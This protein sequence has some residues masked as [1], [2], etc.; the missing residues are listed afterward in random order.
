MRPGR[1]EPFRLDLRHVTLPG[2]Y[3][4]DFEF[5]AQP[6]FRSAFFTWA[7]LRSSAF[8]GVDLT[9]A[10]FTDAD[11]RGCLLVSAKLDEAVLSGADLRGAHLTGASL[12]G[13]LLDGAD[14]RD[15][16]GLTAE[17]LSGA[18]IDG[19]TRLPPELA[20]DAWV[21]ARLAAMPAEA[22]R[23]APAPTPRPG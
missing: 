11:M 23:T 2:I 8:R 3:L 18:L 19:S 7:D 6:S 15:S 1:P 12:L 4:R 14:L 21:R 9:N 16:Q 13:A 5:D 17:Q 10:I 22:T 20:A